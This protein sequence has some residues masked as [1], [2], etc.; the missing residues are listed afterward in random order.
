MT[1]GFSHLRILK[2]S[3]QTVKFSPPVLTPGVISSATVKIRTPST[4]FPDSTEAAT[5]DSADGTLS[6]A[7]SAGARTISTGASLTVGN[8]YHFSTINEGSRDNVGFTAEVL[9]V[10]TN[11][12]YVLRTEVPVNLPT[13]AQIASRT[14][15][16]ALTAAE[17][18]EL[19]FGLIQWRL[20]IEGI[21][22]AFDQVFEVVDQVTAYALD[23]DLLLELCPRLYD[24]RWPKDPTW[25]KS[26]RATWHT[27]I[28]PALLEAGI[29]PDRIESWE[30]LNAAHALYVFA[31]TVQQLGDQFDDRFVS[32]AW[33]RANT[34]L[35][36]AMK[37]RDWWVS[38]GKSTTRDTH[39]GE[40]DDR[41]PS[42]GAIEILR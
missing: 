24:L 15:S 31:W 37:G 35:R 28:E 17:T 1:G 8:R 3:T 30:A 38:T 40:P 9:T 10:D 13:G 18:S 16:H 26:I 33:E 41:V 34:K 21:V 7:A 12:D 4:D 32:S 27:E 39:P 14:V 29:M 42:G 11:M 19:G 25:E 22:Y 2:D 5:V 20:T 36:Q 6:A 23:R